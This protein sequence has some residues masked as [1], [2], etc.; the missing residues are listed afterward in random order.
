QQRLGEDGT[1]ARPDRMRPEGIS[2]P[3]PENHR[4]TDQGEGRPD[5]GAD[6][7]RIRDA[8]QIGT[9]PNDLVR[10][11]LGPDPDRAS[12]GAQLREPVEQRGLDLG[13]PEPLSRG[14]EQLHRLRAGGA[15]RRE[16]VLALCHEQTLA[17]TA[18]PP[19]EAANQ[20]QL[21]VLCA[22]DHWRGPEMKKGGSASRTARENWLWLPS[23]RWRQPPG[24]APQ[25]GE[26]H[27]GR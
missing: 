23:A 26:N 15:G 7:P 12:P 20:L 21:L 6:V 16:Q 3:G 13:P 8:V 9:G 22:G 1:H 14:C 17:L 10:P 19:A 11:A 18:P 5:D 2:G 24:R 27:R 25:I 4:P